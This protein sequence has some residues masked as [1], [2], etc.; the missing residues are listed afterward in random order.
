ME[1]FQ[2]DL[3]SISSPKFVGTFKG[4]KPS[5][6]IDASMLKELEREDFF[7]RLQR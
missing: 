3:D 4:R 1:A 5:D 7:M 6:F 2:F